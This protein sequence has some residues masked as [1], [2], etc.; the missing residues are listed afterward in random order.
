MNTLE[1]EKAAKLYAETHPFKQPNQVPAGKEGFSAGA[2]WLEERLVGQ[3]MERHQKLVRALYTE[4]PG[5]GYEFL[6]GSFNELCDILCLLEHPKYH[7]KH[8]EDWSALPTGH[9]DLPGQDGE[10]GIPFD[11]IRLFTDINLVQELRRRGYDVTCKKTI[12]L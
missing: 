12:E 2:C 4:P 8:P 9:L 5:D 11:T 3:L 1:L 7:D 10:S 6:K